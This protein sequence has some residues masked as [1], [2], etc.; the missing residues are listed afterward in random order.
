MAYLAIRT[1]GTRGIGQTTNFSLLLYGSSNKSPVRSASIQAGSLLKRRRPSTP[2]HPACQL[3]SFFLRLTPRLLPTAPQSFVS[4]HS[5]IH[6][7]IHLPK[8]FITHQ[9]AF[10]IQHYRIRYSKAFKASIPQFVRLN[11]T[12]TCFPPHKIIRRRLRE[13]FGGAS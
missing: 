13:R 11:H 6:F 9:T 4:I 1:G 3:H 5:T 10:G 7:S 8:E 2:S 12:T